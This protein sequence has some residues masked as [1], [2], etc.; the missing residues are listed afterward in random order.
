MPGSRLVTRTFLPTKSAL[1]P[2]HTYHTRTI[3]VQGKMDRMY[4]RL[5]EN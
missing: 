2:T 4:L 5:S 3:H 1:H